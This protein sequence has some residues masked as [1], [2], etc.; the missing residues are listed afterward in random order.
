PP[1]WNNGWSSKVNATTSTTVVR[2]IPTSAPMIA[3]VSQT[4]SE[5][6]AQYVFINLGGGLVTCITFAGILRERKLIG[7]DMVRVGKFV[8][9]NNWIGCA[10]YVPLSVIA[11]NASANGSGAALTH[12]IDNPDDGL[13]RIGVIDKSLPFAS[14]DVSPLVRIVSTVH[15]SDN[16]WKEGG[17]QQVY[18]QS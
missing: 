13:L 8:I 6:V 7:S 11:R 18:E 4:Q 17:R 1:C 14:D 16:D 12:V 9:E 2:I 10:N 5:L 15:R 3:N